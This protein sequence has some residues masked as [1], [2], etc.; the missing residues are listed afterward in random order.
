ME[1]PALEVWGGFECTIA[2]IRDSYRDQCR[3]TGHFDRIEDLE[4]AASLGL[5]RLRYPVLWESFADEATAWAWHDAR[6]S[7]LR[8]LGLGV[9]AGLTHHGG[10]PSGTSLLDTH[11][12]EKLAGHASAVAQRY[13]W[14]EAY[15]PVNEPLTT[16]RFACLYGHWHPHQ[17]HTGAFLLALFHQCRATAAAM[18]AIR[19]VN[20]RAQLVQTE[21]MGRVFSTSKLKLQAEYENERRWLSF[22]LLTGR[23]DSKHPWRRAF[24]DAGVQERQLD[25]ISH[26]PCPPD[27]VG[28]NHYLTSD[29]YLDHR[30][31]DYPPEFRGGNGRQA[32]VDVAA[33]RANVPARDFGPRAR[34]QEAWDRYGLPLAVTEVHNGS[35]REEQLRWL[36][37]VWWAANDVAQA[38][39]DV[40]A[41]TV[42]SL[43]GAVDWN[44]LLTRRDGFYEPGAFD[45]RTSPPRPTAL[46]S[47]VRALTSQACFDH[48]CLDGAGWWRRSDRYHRAQ[49]CAPAAAGGRRTRRLAVSDPSTA[50]GAA[51]MN[52]CQRRDLAVV[53]APFPEAKG[54]AWAVIDTG[55]VAPGASAMTD[56]AQRIGAPLVRF[57]SPHLF[58]PLK[59]RAYRESDRPTPAN[60]RGRRAAAAEDDARAR[61]PASL[62]VRTGPMFSLDWADAD[63]AA[64]MQMVVSGRREAASSLT[65]IPDL[66]DAVLDLLIDEAWG[67]WH[68]VNQGSAA[69]E[70][71]S[72]PVNT[73][74]LA[75][76]TDCATITTERGL[77]LPPLEGRLAEFCAG[78]IGP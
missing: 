76:P 20:P 21:D 63:F 61:A 73:E 45:V 41:V 1:R 48:P 51:F 66:V 59:G 23:V 62:L 55:D 53:T 49:W 65:Y 75:Q 26:E 40:R 60:E 3:D 47:A 12:P 2:R 69:P 78:S 11:Y 77:W 17:A 54:R 14:L 27:I 24:L 22:D 37:E 7:R 57:S 16:A 56:F 64:M 50:L 30:V 44:S 33:A 72:A 19:R 9:I 4:R 36:A 6:F 70:N 34:L 8:A 31:A 46:A 38:G 15:T 67:T 28:V 5:R 74:P 52:A 10:G 43:A 25:E 68:L 18:K 39:A 13:P 35:T 71:M 58:K 29:R 32:Y 42:W